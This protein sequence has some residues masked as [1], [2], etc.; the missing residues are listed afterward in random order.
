[1]SLDHTHYV[2]DVRWKQAEKES[3]QSLGKEEKSRL[4]PLIELI[5]RNFRTNDDEELPTRDALRKIAK[6]IDN[7][8]GFSATFVDL[9]HVIS[10]GIRGAGDDPHILEIL[11]EETR[12]L[13]PLLPRESN[14]IPVT[15]LNRAEDYQ[16]AV[17]SIIEEDKT[18]ACLRVT[19]G[20]VSHMS[21]S[22]KLESVLFQLKLDVLDADL[23][24][25]LQCP[26]GSILNL[27][28]LCTAIPQL[29]KWRSFTVLSGAFPKDLQDMEKDSVHT[30][31]RDE[32]FYWREQVQLLPTGMR[33]PTFGDYTVQHAI[34]E[35]PKEDCNPSASIRYTYDDYWVILRGHGLKHKGSLGNAQYPAEA[36]LLCDMDEFCRAGFSEGDR[37][38]YETSQT[39]NKPGTPFTWLRAGINHHMV[40]TVRQIAEFLETVP[41]AA[42]RRTA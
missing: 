36:Q 15:G 27:Q 7:Y 37:Y 17:A 33:W 20:D 40:Y 25:D 26:N 11:A 28:A 2:A 39:P 9:E 13:L 41:K 6:E 32:W 12:R 14:L 18:G 34:F 10:R 35:E 21:F 38:I 31:P 8:W 42:S 22:T 5:P 19:L 29:S 30:L 24:V 16:A 3:L 4:T 23:V 1:M